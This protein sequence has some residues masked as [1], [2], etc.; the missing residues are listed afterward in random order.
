MTSRVAIRVWT[1][2]LLIGLFGVHEVSAQTP[3][4][5]YTGDGLTVRIAEWN[6]VTGA[7]RG[8]IVK[9]GNTFPFTGQHREAA[10][11]ETVTGT[12][13]AGDQ[14]FD[15]TTRQDAGGD[16]VLFT[17]GGKT[18][19]LRPVAA[20]KPPEPAKPQPV[21][22][23]G[24]D[25]PTSPASPAAPPAVSPVTPPVAP[26]AA[27]RPAD[28][29]AP[30]TDAAAN[31]VY[32]FKRNAFP[33]VTMGVAEAYTVLTPADWVCDGRVEWRNIGEVPF[34]QTLF[35]I[36]SPRGGR[37]TYVPN[38]TFSYSRAPGMGQQGVP[39]PQ[40]FDQWFV[41]TLPKMNPKVSNVRMVDAQRQ[42][43]LEE[44][45]VA[46]DRA[47][48][49]NTQGMRREIWLLNFEY[50]L[51]GVRRREESIITFVAYAPF[52]GLNGFHTQ[53]WGLFFTQF[54]SAPA[55]L[56]EKEKPALYGAVG[57]V[58]PTLRWF[59][60][61][62]AVIAE[63]SRQRSANIWKSIKDRG[64]QIK[65][66]HVTKADESAYNSGLNSDASH[67]QRMNTLNETD[68]YKD[69]DGSTVNLPIHGKY[70]FSDGQG[71]IVVTD[72]YV[73]PGENYQE[74]TPAGQ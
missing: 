73:K 25:A 23:L 1:T 13:K 26:P 21:N 57:S 18:Y 70:K 44:M 64:E 36:T 32:R 63:N 19:R 24:G 37:V 4:M 28:A 60:A 59:T 68:D 35:T 2:G 42:A 3:P 47:T 53:T 72:R 58:R 55:D 34:P 7:L 41:E 17:T 62:Q 49:A 71:N 45:G 56:W 10:D 66:M 52:N 29:A 14:S 8:E 33:D 22:P 11:A 39:V 74:I 48:N 61:S 31:G 6:E 5:T 67:R 12:F 43:K 54:V 38:L 69:V 51:D 50:D 16:A 9:G 46:N 40:Q 65:N 15:F 27:P 20:E 30:P